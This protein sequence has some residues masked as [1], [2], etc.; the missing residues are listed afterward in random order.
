MCVQVPGLA[1][2]ARVSER[3]CVAHAAVA[4]EESDSAARS[5]VVGRQS[6]TGQPVVHRGADPRVVNSAAGARL[7]STPPVLVVAHR[8][9]N[10]ATASPRPCHIVEVVRR[11]VKIRCKLVGAVVAD[12]KFVASVPRV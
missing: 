3:G 9:A 1:L 10:V 5:D 4:I 12:F 2:L 7:V 6:H 11:V 8:E